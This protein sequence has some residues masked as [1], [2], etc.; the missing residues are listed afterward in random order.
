MERYAWLVHGSQAT[1]IAWIKDAP[2]GVYFSPRDAVISGRYH[3]SY[4]TQ[5]Q[6][7]L[8]AGD[9]YYIGSKQAT[10]LS[11]LD[12][13]AN[14]G[15]FGLEPQGFSWITDAKV[16]ARDVVLKYNPAT[17]ID[18]PA[19]V[20]LHI[21]ARASSKQLTDRIWSSG[22]GFAYDSAMFNLKAYPNLIAVLV[23]QFQVK[24]HES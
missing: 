3:Y 7:H 9:R 5:G 21:A 11:E 22:P 19:L 16:K 14:I 17:R 24:V 1:K 15:G 10:A 6:R 8:K 20:S 12:G 4:H 18:L 23:L 13:S 2:S